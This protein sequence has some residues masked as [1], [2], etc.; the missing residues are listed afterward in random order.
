MSATKWICMPC[1]TNPNKKALAIKPFAV[2]KEI[3]ANRP[4]EYCINPS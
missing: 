1:W 3:Y 4:K 2:T